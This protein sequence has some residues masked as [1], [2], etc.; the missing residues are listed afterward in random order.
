MHL[1]DWC[2]GAGADRRIARSLGALPPFKV[3]QVSIF[4]RVLGDGLAALDPGELGIVDADLLGGLELGQA[5]GAA[6]L[7]EDLAEVRRCR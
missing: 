1:P 4:R 3:S 7:P 6:G 5:V 2:S